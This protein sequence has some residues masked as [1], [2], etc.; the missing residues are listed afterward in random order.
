MSSD[1]EG[2]AVLITGAASGIGR[3]TARQF[4]KE[5]ARVVV[6]DLDLAGAEETIAGYSGSSAIRCDVSNPADVAAAV[7][8]TVERCGGLDVLVNN[9]GAVT[10]A[11]L[12][13]LTP[14]QFT[15]IQQVNIAGT[16]YGIKYA[17]PR[18]AERGG[19]AIVST[20][21]DAGLRGTV[22]M[23]AYG[24]SKAAVINLTQTAALELRPLGIRVNCVC[25]G[26]IATPM[27]DQIRDQFESMIGTSFDEVV[28]MKQGQLGEPEDIA[29]AVLYLASPEA[30]FI[31][32]VALSV[33]N[34]LA[35]GLF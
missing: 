6:A 35:A 7:A 28:A 4:A 30:A 21:S 3:A 18:I 12:T 11:P 27:L 5:G 25:P 20:A 22:T 34:A 15:R 29:R 33:D 17:A 13:E 14:E 31:S 9:A 24:A 23:G 16:F 19:G 26:L 8:A 2:K 10:V 32:G 1:W